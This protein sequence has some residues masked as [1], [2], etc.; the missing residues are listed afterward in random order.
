MSKKRCNKQPQADRKQEPLTK[1]R[2]TPHQSNPARL[3]L[4]EL[5]LSVL[6]DYAVAP[7]LS[8]AE[9][10]TLDSSDH[11]NIEVAKQLLQIQMDDP[12]WA[13]MAWLVSGSETDS[14]QPT[15]GESDDWRAK[16]RAFTLH[17]QD[18]LDDR[19]TPEVVRDLFENAVVEANNQLGT[20]FDIREDI[21]RLVDL[22]SPD[23]GPDE[24]NKQPQPDKLK[25]SS[26]PRPTVFDLCDY[27]GLYLEFV[28]GRDTIFI[29][30]F[31]RQPYEAPQVNFEVIGQVETFLH[32]KGFYAPPSKSAKHHTGLIEIDKDG[33][34]IFT[35]WRGAKLFALDWTMSE[36]SIEGQ[37][38]II[39]SMGHSQHTLLFEV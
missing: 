24:K 3:N 23:R 13:A 26:Q 12:R 30:D 19:R 28:I 25:P 36:G 22:A 35:G 38:N 37:F 33:S 16:F 7:V 8:V 15:D 1:G 20:P 9:L 5:A 32:R 39:G 27:T 18:L 14:Q 21:G 31:D 29:F 11:P 6:P 17:L 2:L 10:F 34:M 4:I